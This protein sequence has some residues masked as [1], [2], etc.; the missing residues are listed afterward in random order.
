MIDGPGD[1]FP[2]P[3]APCVPLSRPKS[4]NHPVYAG[5]SAQSAGI[6]MKHAP[7]PDCAYL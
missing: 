3:V 1:P 7:S 4:E 6:D 2:S 5:R